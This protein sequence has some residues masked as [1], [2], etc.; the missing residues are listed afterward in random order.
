MTLVKSVGGGKRPGCTARSC[1]R[2]A[3]ALSADESVDAAGLRESVE[4]RSR[5]VGKRG[6]AEGGRTTL[7]ER[8]AP[9]L[10]ALEP[11]WP[12]GGLA[13]ALA[14]PQ[15]R[16][17]RVRDCNGIH[18][19]RK[20]TP[21]TSGR[22][23]SAFDPG[24]T[25]EKVLITAAASRS[26]REGDAVTVGLVSFR[27]A[28]HSPRRV[29]AGPK[30]DVE[31]RQADPSCRRRR[32]RRDARIRGTDAQRR[33]STPSQR[34]ISG[35]RRR[36]AEISARGGALG[37]ARA[38]ELL[39]DASGRRVVGFLFLPPITSRGIGGRRGGR[40]PAEIERGSRGSSRCA[41][42][43]GHLGRARRGA[44]EAQP[45]TRGQPASFFVGK[46]R[47]GTC[48]PAERMVQEVSR[49]RNGTRRVAIAATESNGLNEGSLSRSQTLVCG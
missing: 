47:T 19:R 35:A 45:D 12:P 36:G 23:V 4:C 13:A 49:A 37:R 27:T 33:S 10:D 46:T 7:F 44:A 6:R 31:P 15:L 2:M 26:R 40:G 30:E 25:S 32:P 1:L 22:A 42:K 21:A 24:A 14:T 28:G 38:V 43:I 8:Y 48:R 11:H 5:G 20:A 34:R 18:G 9:A 16:P 29:D 3:G 17:K 41:A 39:D